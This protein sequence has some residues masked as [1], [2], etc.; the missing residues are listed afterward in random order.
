MNLVKFFLFCLISIVLFSACGSKQLMKE[1]SSTKSNVSTAKKVERQFDKNL[2]G[3][4][5]GKEDGN[6]IEGMQK[7]WTMDRTEDGKFSIVFVI[8]TFGIQ[9]SFYEEGSWYTN[10]GV[11]YEYHD[12]SGLTDIYYYTV[13]SDKQNKYTAKSLSIDFENE[14]YTYIETRVEETIRGMR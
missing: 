14:A 1:S 9:Q 6:Q 12:V 11:Y 7:S 2:V 5:T 4:F 3:S 10:D 13:L 8:N